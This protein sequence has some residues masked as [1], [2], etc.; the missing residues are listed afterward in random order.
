MRKQ[1]RKLAYYAPLVI[2]LGSAYF[3]VAKFVKNTVVDNDIPKLTHSVRYPFV[4]RYQD[5][6]LDDKQVLEEI[7][8]LRKYS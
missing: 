2:I 4:S 8:Q 7:K 3:T 5:P 6:Q 1:V